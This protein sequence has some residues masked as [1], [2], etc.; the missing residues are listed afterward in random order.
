MQQRHRHFD[1]MWL[2]VLLELTLPWFHRGIASQW[3]ELSI[4]YPHLIPLKR[5][6]RC[7]WICG[8]CQSILPLRSE[9]SHNRV[10][11]KEQCQEEFAVGALSIR[12]LLWKKCWCSSTMSPWSKTKLW[13]L[14]W[15]CMIL[16][17]NVLKLFN[18]FPS[19]PFVAK[20][21]YKWLQCTS[22]VIFNKTGV[23]FLGSIGVSVEE[24][25]VR[26]SI[27][28]LG[29]PNPGPVSDEIRNFLTYFSRPRL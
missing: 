3:S 26:M 28:R 17:Y 24:F 7:T 5:I 16:S 14:H 10:N 13:K 23:L 2:N 22:I 19:L 8:K 11:V 29:S 15:F 9:R 20:D 25:L 18:P 27:V 4:H 21:A 6:V 12:N 1:L